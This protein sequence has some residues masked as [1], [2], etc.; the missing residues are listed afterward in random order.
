LGC[1]TDEL[2]V[3][4]I[5]VMSAGIAAAPGSPPAAQANAIMQEMGL[6]ISNHVSQ[7]ITGRLAQ[8]A[9]VILTM[10]SGHRQ[11]LV[12]HWPTLESRTFTIRSDG[13]DVSDP[14]GASV[15]VY[16]KCA[17]QINEQL[18]QWA[19]SYDFSQFKD[20]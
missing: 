14:I 10:T 3:K 2:L 11:A 17:N 8:Y 19:T 6:D 18:A 1:S 5:T 16:R 4:G 7:P 13:G 20:K 12:S 15:E 9:D